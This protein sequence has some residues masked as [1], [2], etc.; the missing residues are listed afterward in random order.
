LW[1]NCLGWLQTW[2]SWLSAFWVSR[3][4]GVS[5]QCPACLFI[6]RLLWIELFSPFL[7]HPV[8]SW[9]IEKLQ[10]FVRLFL[11]PTTFPKVFI[12]FRGFLLASLESFKYRII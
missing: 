6:F 2:S 4:I 11:S 3:I 7:S 8:H 10:I 1:T 5:H 9:Y 12:R